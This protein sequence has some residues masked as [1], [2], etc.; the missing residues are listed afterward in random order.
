MS[1]L[2][3]QFRLPFDHL[4][5]AKIQARNEYGFGVISDPNTEPMGA[6]IQTEPVDVKNVRRGSATSES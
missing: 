3:T 2:R 1:V 4:I 5:Q 6:K